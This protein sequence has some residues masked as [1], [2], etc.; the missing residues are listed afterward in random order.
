MSGQWEYQFAT[1]DAGTGGWDDRVIDMLAKWGAQGWEPVNHAV[2][3]DHDGFPI[4]FTFLFKHRV[5]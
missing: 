2:M 1:L 4:Y 5:A 3:A